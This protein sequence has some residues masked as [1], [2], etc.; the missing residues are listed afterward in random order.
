MPMATAPATKWIMLHAKQF[1]AGCATLLRPPCDHVVIELADGTFHVFLNIPYSKHRGDNKNKDRAKEWAAALGCDMA[2]ER[3][4]ARLRDQ[5]CRDKDDIKRFPICDADADVRMFMTRSLRLPGSA[6]L[7]GAPARLELGAEAEV[8]AFD[9]YVYL[10]KAACCLASV[11]GRKHTLSFLRAVHAIADVDGR[12]VHLCG[13]G[14]YEDEL[15]R[16]FGNQGFNVNIVRTW[17]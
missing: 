12:T 7:P 17:E 14:K 5:S 2:S 13:A 15:T 16:A 4:W 9:A 1:A 11:V 3:A 6:L 8:A 10:F